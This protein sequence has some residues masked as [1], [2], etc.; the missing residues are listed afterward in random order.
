MV[1][2]AFGPVRELVREDREGFLF[3]PGEAGSLRAALERALAHPDLD[4]LG[5]AGLEVARRFA[6]PN[7]AAMT[8]ECYHEALER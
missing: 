5:Q 6:W 7:I 8:A 4:A 1:A 3:A 2:P